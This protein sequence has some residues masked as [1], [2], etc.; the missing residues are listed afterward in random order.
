MTISHDLSLPHTSWARWMKMR[1]SRTRSALISTIGC[2]PKLLNP[3]PRCMHVFTVQRPSP[4]TSTSTYPA[5]LLKHYNVFSNMSE[6]IETTKTTKVVIKSRKYSNWY[7]INDYSRWSV[8]HSV[9][10]FRWDPPW[11]WVSPPKLYV[12]VDGGDSK[13]KN[14]T[15]EIKGNPSVWD[16]EI[17]LLVFLRLSPLLVE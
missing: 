3:S 14:K 4:L 11:S 16:K 2:F 9:E 15:D 13:R 1:G 6:T 5:L 7:V 8:V 17:P 12:R 10:G